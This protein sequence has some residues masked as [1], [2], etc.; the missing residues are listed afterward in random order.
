MKHALVCVMTPRMALATWL[1]NVL[2]PPRGVKEP[3]GTDFHA[4]K[5]LAPALGRPGKGRFCMH[6]SVKP[7][8]S[9]GSVTCMTPYVRQNSLYF[10]YIQAGMGYDGAVEADCPENGIDT[11]VN[12]KSGCDRQGVLH[13]L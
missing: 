7:S 9:G 1:N 5:R 8:R 6:S 12:N 2:T 10:A 4:P 13:V 3:H 11:A